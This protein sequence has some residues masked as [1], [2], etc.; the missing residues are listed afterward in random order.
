MPKP[1]ALVYAKKN[2][3]GTMYVA[4]RNASGDYLDAKVIGAGSTSG[5]KLRIVM[6]GGVVI[7]NV[8]PQTTRTQ[9][10]VYRTTLNAAGSG[11]S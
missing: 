9:T 4:Y 7:D 3:G 8:Q 1:Q 2:H 5:L 11:A 6:S 10:G